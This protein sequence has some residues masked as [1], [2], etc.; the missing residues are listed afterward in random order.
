MLHYIIYA[1]IFEVG[2]YN[3]I[4]KMGIPRD[5]LVKKSTQYFK[6]LHVGFY[7]ITFLTMDG[8]LWDLVHIRL[9]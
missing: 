5:V 4:I 1:T 6:P 7:S 9:G 8:F 2:K 3:Y